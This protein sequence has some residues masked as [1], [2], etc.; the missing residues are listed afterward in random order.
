M[1]EYVV[2]FKFSAGILTV[3][4]VIRLFLCAL[5]VARFFVN[6]RDI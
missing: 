2:I 6:H 4:F 3:P 1:R 5:Y